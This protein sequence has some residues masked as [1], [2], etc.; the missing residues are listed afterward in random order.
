M[1][2]LTF[3]ELFFYNINLF[4]CQF[5]LKATDVGG[6]MFIHMFGCYFGWAFKGVLVE[7]RAVSR[8]I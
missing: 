8:Q 2:Y 1:F 3:F 5:S 7:R 4:V 6:S